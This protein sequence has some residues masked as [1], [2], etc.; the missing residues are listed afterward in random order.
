MSDR[1]NGVSN[2]F[3]EI[4]L[5]TFCTLPRSHR[6]SLTSPQIGDLLHTPSL[7]RLS[8]LSFGMAPT[9]VS[10]IV[11]RMIPTLSSW[12]FAHP[13]SDCMK[14]VC[15]RVM[16][17]R[18]DWTHEAHDS[19]SI[20]FQTKPDELSVHRPVQPGDLY[21]DLRRVGD[22]EGHDNVAS[23]DIR[24][25]DLHVWQVLGQPRGGGAT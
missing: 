21:A 22:L 17:G 20:G 16:T 19:L 9:R 7:W 13:C 24:C 1:C 2:S 23:R 4:S 25:C 14:R 3:T 6:P 18:H 10:R 12:W 8:M 15:G 11:W 5:R